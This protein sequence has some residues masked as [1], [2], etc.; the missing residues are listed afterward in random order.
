MTLSNYDTFLFW[1]FPILTLSHSDTFQFWHFPILTL[2]NS[3]T[4]QFWHFP[5]SQQKPKLMQKKLLWNKKN[6]KM[7][8]QW[9]LSWSFKDCFKYL[10]LIA[11]LSNLVVFEW[12]RYSTHKHAEL[13]RCTNEHYA[14]K[15]NYNAPELL[16]CRSLFFASYLKGRQPVR[17][18]NFFFA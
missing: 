10:C 2:S 15:L 6:W 11:S 16:N 13:E 9:N 8:N 3:D 7:G 12:M 4:F 17:I 1:H 18:A 5:V 14:F